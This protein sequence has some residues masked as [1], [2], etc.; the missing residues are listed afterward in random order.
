MSD[1]PRNLTLPPGAVTPSLQSRIDRAL[2][3]PAT[4]FMDRPGKQLRARLV[5]AGVWLAGGVKVPAITVA[6]AGELLEQIH[7]GSLIVDDIQDHG[8][9]RRGRPALHRLHGVPVALN[10]GNWLYFAPLEG[11]SRWG[12]TPEQELQVYR[13]CSEALSLA[14]GGQALDVSTRIDEVPQAEVATVCRAS[15]EFK[16]GALTDLAL[17][18]GGVLAGASDERLSALRT[19]GRRFGT[20]LQMFDDLGN[21][22]DPLRRYDDLLLRRPSF[23]WASVAETM[24][25]RDYAAFVQAVQALP[26]ESYLHPW[27]E[28]HRPVEFGMKLARSF[29]D[30]ARRQFERTLAEASNESVSRGLAMIDELAKVLSE[31][32]VKPE[33]VRA[34]EEHSLAEKAV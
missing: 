1:D 9:L 10:V 16:S 27:L 31:A 2:I 21:L 14:H 28:I 4:E 11:V 24:S 34:P 13:L 26:N 22:E 32:Y 25:E 3:G 6:R 7:A 19:F 15:I 33:S 8:A 17:S 18:I 30:E 5:E 12:I 23:V 20:A 29:L